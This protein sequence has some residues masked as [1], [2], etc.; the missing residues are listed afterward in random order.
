MTV[1]R[2][3][4]GYRNLALVAVLALATLC[5][6]SLGWQAPEDL[7]QRKLQAA[8]LIT[9]GRAPAAL[10]RLEPLSAKLPKDAEIKILIGEAHFVM[11]KYGVAIRYFEL[12]LGLAPPD[13]SNTNKKTARRLSGGLFPD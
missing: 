12:G 7:P 11:K 8:D 2:N 10:E 1:F 5:A 6:G 4:R 9:S 13:R 3:N